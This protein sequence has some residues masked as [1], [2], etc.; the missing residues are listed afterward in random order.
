MTLGKKLRKAHH[1]WDHS[2]WSGLRQAIG[3]KFFP[4]TAWNRY[5]QEAMVYA[6]WMDFSQADIQ[7]SRSL[8]ENFPGELNFSSL[9][10]FLPEFQH[11]YY[12]GVH[13]LLRFAD[14]FKRVK[15]VDNQFLI[16]GTVSEGQVREKIA[17]SFPALAGESIR[18][19]NLAEDIRGIEGTDAAI[20]TLWGTAY[21]MLNFNQT[22]RKF[23]FLQDY[24]PLFYPAGSTFAQVE[25]SYRFGYYGIANTPTIQKIYEEQYGGR[26]EYFMPCVDT[27]IFHPAQDGDQHSAGPA[28]IFFYG[29]PAHPRN[30]FELGAQ[31]LRKLKKRLGDQVRIVAAGDRWEPE[32][33]GLDGVVDNLGL[34]GYEETAALYRTCQIGLVMMFT[35]HPSYLPFEFM[36]SGCLVLTNYNPATTWLLKDGENCRLS[37]ASATCLADALEQA[38]LDR[39]GRERITANAVRQMQSSFSDWDCQI[40]KIH[41]YMCNPSVS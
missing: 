27:R 23:Y 9:S 15:G 41:R 38:L 17:K 39:E 19:Y 5:S 35:R 14:Y 34:L 3:G 29:R 36:A 33:Y 24:E 2:G 7:A 26:A 1:I 10:W 11:P 6:S 16:L 22:R 28:T 40:E 30:G 12:G 20:A 21:F 4:G 13:T 18:T 37:E 32:H 25:A 31:A 8:H